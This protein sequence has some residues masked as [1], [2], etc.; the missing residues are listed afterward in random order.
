MGRESIL[1]KHIRLI[2]DRQ[3]KFEASS[4]YS[5]PIS[6]ICWKSGGGINFGVITESLKY[7]N[8]K[9]NV[10]ELFLLDFYLYV[11]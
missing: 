5:P 7:E 2:V 6:R 11:Y 1:A 9:I 3:S 10:D 8:I 4:F